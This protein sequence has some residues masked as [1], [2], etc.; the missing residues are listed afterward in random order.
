M[1]RTRYVF[2]IWHYPKFIASTAMKKSDSI[3]NGSYNK[4]YKFRNASV[5]ISMKSYRVLFTSYNCLYQI[6][7]DWQRCGSLRHIIMTLLK[8]KKEIREKRKRRCI[9]FRLSIKHKKTISI[10][11]HWKIIEFIILTQVMFIYENTFY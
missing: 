10:Y 5:F 1:S 4:F 2:S 8:K 11:L 7:N 3:I 6:K 9:R